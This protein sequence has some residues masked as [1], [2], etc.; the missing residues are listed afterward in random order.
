MLRTVLSLAAV[1]AA[2]LACAPTPPPPDAD[3]IEAA[4]LARSDSAVTAYVAAVDAYA[5]AMDDA[6]LP[7]PLLRAGE[8]SALRRYG[9]SDHVDRARALGHDRVPSLDAARTDA[10]AGRLVRLADSTATY[11]IRELEHSHPYLTPDAAALLDDLGR[12][13]QAR[14]AEL[15]LPPLRL[16]V[17]SVLRTP[18]LQADLRQ[19]NTNAARGVSSHE[20]GTTLDV[21]YS[22]FAAP[23][24]LP[25][26]IDTAEAWLAPFL[27]SYQVAR[28]E[29]VAAR[30]SR[31]LQAL[32]GQVL[33][34]LQS[35]GAVLALLEIRQPVY[36]LTVAR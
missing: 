31:E 2:A 17:T 25:I 9:S 20:F 14:I 7:I 24:D 13:F 6:L 23:A 32:L 12:R 36:H 5:D 1:T 22:A 10:E 26:A 21:A 33:I 3:A 27:R 8:E 35:K 4:L 29:Q 28:I 15:G 11:V 19:E 34:D 18:A 16:E 30:R